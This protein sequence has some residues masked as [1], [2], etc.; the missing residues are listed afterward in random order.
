MMNK[1]MTFSVG[2]RLRGAFAVTILFLVAL[3]A[4]AAASLRAVNAS[5]HL[6]VDDRYL[7]VQTVTRIKEELN[8]Q[9]R[10]ARNVLIFEGAEKIAGQLAEIA[11]AQAHVRELYAALD[12][13]IDSNEL[14]QARAGVER[15]R[16]RYLDEYKKFAALVRE[17]NMTQAK[18][19]LVNQL[20]DAQL[21]YMSGLDRF[22][23]LSEGLMTEAAKDADRV[24]NTGM[25]IVAVLGVGATL[26]ALLLAHVISR[27]ITVPLARAL[28][29]A[30]TVARGDL[31]SRFDGIRGD[32]EAAKLL[33]ALS[34]M[35]DSLVNIVGSVRGASESIA[36]GSSEIAN[37]NTD[38]SQR[39]EEQASN[40]QQTAASMDE[41][42][43]T[44]ANNA[45]RSREAARLAATAA[46][47]AAQGGVAMRDVVQMMAEISTSSVKIS[48][49]IGVI[50][51][52]A[53]QTNILAL[54][55]AVEAAR[56]GEQGRGFAVVATEVRSLAQRS[57]AAAREIKVLIG[58]SVEKVEAGNRLVEGAG[59]TMSETVAQV[60]D[61]NDLITE[62]STSNGEQSIGIGQVGDAVGQLDQVTQQNAALVEESAAAAESLRQQADQ[63]ALL[64]GRFTL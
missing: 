56:A 57:A 46:E 63:L 27:S 28:Q 40:L 32:D 39:T 1:L 22:T 60:R 61:V 13:T 33:Q 62:I 53:F 9:A 31:R 38:L 54:N 41:L 16:V 6:V 14:K 19:Q 64:V 24:E 8:L 15:L 37:G 50:D 49:I 44:V 5:F 42:K 52:I 43:T 51:G 59:R 25:R 3:A 34:R 47:V 4:V 45:E 10:A 20:R 21:A 18:L 11:K 17:D 2:T 48:E 58:E 35:N 23:E 55:A 30:E 26:V 29:V 12:A 36:T 7:K